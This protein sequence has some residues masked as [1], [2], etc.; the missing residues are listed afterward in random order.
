MIQDNLRISVLLT[1]QGALLGE[2]GSTVRGVACS[3]DEK[4]ISIQTIFD[5]EISEEDQESMEF[6]VTEVMASFPEHQVDLSCIRL[7]SPAK[8]TL[9]ASMTLV[10]ERKESDRS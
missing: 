4:T 1:M 7:D 2:I 5:G 6:V 3:W 8:I 9:D 10:Y